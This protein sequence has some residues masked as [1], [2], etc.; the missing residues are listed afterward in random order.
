MPEIQ[1]KYYVGRGPEVEDILARAKKAWDDVLAARK[2][3][4]EEYQANGFIPGDRRRYTVTGFL[5]YEKPGFDFMKYQPSD[6]KENDPKPDFYRAYPNTRH[7]EGRQLA[8]KLASPAVT[9]DAKNELVN[10]LGVNCMA[11]FRASANQTS[12]SMVWS[13]AK[14][15]ENIVLVRMPADASKQHILGQAPRIPKFLKLV[16]KDVFDQLESGDLTPLQS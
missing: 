13:E 14:Q 16:K 5:Y 7:L 4:R 15:V 6:V 10:L 1:W 9:F 2:A 11:D 8:E 3:L 12:N